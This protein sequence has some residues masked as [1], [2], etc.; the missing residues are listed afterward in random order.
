MAP[1]LTRRPKPPNERISAPP[2]NNQNDNHPR[3]LR[4]NK[5]AKPQA[6]IPQKVSSW[7]MENSSLGNEYMDAMIKDFTKLLHEKSGLPFSFSMNKISDRTFDAMAELANLAFLKSLIEKI[8]KACDIDASV[9]LAK[10]CTQEHR[11]AVFLIN[12]AERDPAKNK[13][14]ISALRQVIKLHT[15]R[16]FEQPVNILLVLANAESVIESH[17]YKIGAKKIVA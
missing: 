2:K 4:Q 8:L 17:L 3:P 16:F 6:F 12:P 1:K 10:Y 14:L 13:D 7:P 5:V 9:G 11:F 15:L